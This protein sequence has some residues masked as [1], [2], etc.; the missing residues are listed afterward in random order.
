M[1]TDTLE[2]C[3]SRVSTYI[4]TGHRRVA[5][6]NQ[7]EGHAVICLTQLWFAGVG[8]CKSFMYHV[9]RDAKDNDSSHCQ[10]PLDSS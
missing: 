2:S 4:D 6:N 10:G 7:W 5:T 1:I 3:C 9:I 8:T